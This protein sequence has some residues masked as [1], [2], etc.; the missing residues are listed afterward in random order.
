VT[1]APVPAAY[2][3]R[4]M[5]PGDLWQIDGF[6]LKTYAIGLPGAAPPGDPLRAAARREAEARL[7]QAALAEG[8]AHGLGFVILH[9]GAQ[10]VWLLM[11]WWAHRE[12]CC[13]RLSRADPG[14][15]DFAAVDHRPLVACVW[16]MRVLDRGDAD[17]RAVARALPR[18]YPAGRRVLT[19]APMRLVFMGSPEFAVPALEALSGAG[20]EIVCVYSQPPRPAGRGQR[21]R[22]APVAAR[23][24]GLGLRVRTPARLRDAGDRAAFA[25]LRPEVA[26]VAA[27]GLILPQPVLDAPERGAL[28]IHASLLPR[29]RGA[30]PI[31][32]AIMAGD[33]ETGISIMA[34][35]AGLDTG[36]VLA[37]T[38]TPI[39]PR[40]TAG[41]LHDRLAALGAETIVRALAEL[42]R[43][44]PE[45]QPEAGVTYAAKLDKAEARIDW[46]RPASAVDR[47]VRGLSPAPGAWTE[48][49]GERVRVLLAEPAEGDGPAGTALDASLRVACGGGAVRLLRLQRPGR[50]PMPAD[51]FLRGFAVPAGA[52]LG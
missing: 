15:A 4:P 6:R 44:V 25:A 17:R 7:P 2:V 51:A 13:G 5:A 36:P 11:H 26:V 41:S 24:A 52:R 32:R 43:L 16:E 21:P 1:A 38:V 8:E 9:E 12:I 42:D 30:A 35:E 27:Y 39:G 29:W 3:P 50:A 14:S 34:M 47:H 40:E 46:T 49:G 18:R 23:A 10:G 20:H 33:T 48:V 19:A 37:R 22:P 28:N 31:Q 45:P